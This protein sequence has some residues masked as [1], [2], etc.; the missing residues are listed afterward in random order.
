MENC[1][2]NFSSTSKLRTTSTKHRIEMGNPIH[3]PI[4]AI[5]KVEDISM[6]MNG[7]FGVFTGGDHDFITQARKFKCARVVIGQHGADMANMMFAIHG[8]LQCIIEGP[9]ID[10]PTVFSS[11]G[12]GDES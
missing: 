9:K 1:T 10:H 7:S 8:R 12:I 5:P 4:H 11:D 3:A 2:E 6:S